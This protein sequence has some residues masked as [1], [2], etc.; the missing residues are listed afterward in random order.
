MKTYRDFSDFLK[1][2]FDVKVQ[3]ITV[4]AGFTC[5]NR[6]G[7]KGR[8]GCTYCNN[9]SFNP[10]YCR[11]ALSVRE[12]LERG[13]EFFARKYPQMKYL[14]YF[15]AYTNTHSDDIDRLMRLYEEALETPDV[16]G[17]IIGTRPDC[18]PQELIDRLAGLGK[19]V[20]VEYGAESACDRTLELVNRCHTWADTADAVRRTH[21]TGIPCGLHLIMGL[22]G[23]DEDVMLSTIDRVN[24]LPV[25]TVK[26]HQLQLVR[27]TR[28]ARDVEAGLYD[29]PRFTAEEYADL[30]VRLLRRLRK[31]IA[32]E[33]F[34]S[35][36]P[37]ELLIYPRW[38]LKNYQFTNL[39]NNRLEA[40]ARRYEAL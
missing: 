23:E 24:E 17:L 28:M 19:W 22:P 1:E 13:K 21:E 34:V 16:V 25:D 30:C 40:D 33:R 35:Q 18:M 7:T 36:S 12:Q 6:D 26:I 39:L 29:I 32:V 31:D 14:A 4:N 2:H 9:Q 37:S 15:Q 8:G 10:E 3:K 11:P 20:M 27:G 5:P 38:G